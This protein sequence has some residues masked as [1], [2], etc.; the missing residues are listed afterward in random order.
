[1]HLWR[2]RARYFGGAREFW[3][4]GSGGDMA[5]G[6]GMDMPSL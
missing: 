2:W 4:E 6:L 5:T 3:D 1:M